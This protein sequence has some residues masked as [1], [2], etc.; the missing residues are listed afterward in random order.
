MG[1]LAAPTLSDMIAAQRTAVT[2]ARAAFG[3]LGP[4]VTVHEAILHKLTEEARRAGPFGRARALA[5]VARAPA[6]AGLL[7]KGLQP[8]HVEALRPQAE[9]NRAL[10]EVLE[11]LAGAPPT[12]R[13]WVRQRLEPLA[14]PTAWRVR[15]HRS[16]LPARLV[17]LTKKAYLRAL[18]PAARQV[19][20]GQRA[21]NLQVIAL[22][23]DPAL[24]R[25][26]SSPI[27]AEAP[28]AWLRPQH[29]FNQHVAGMLEAG[30][31]PGEPPALAGDRAAYVRQVQGMAKVLDFS[32]AEASTVPRHALAH[33]PRRLTWFLPFF[34]HPFGGVHTILRFADAWRRDHGVENR[35]VIYDNP[36]VTARELEAKVA[37]LYPEAPGT[38]EI[39]KSPEAVAGLAECDVAIATLWSSAYFALRHRKAR[40]RAYFIQDYEPLFY[41]AGTVS[42]LAQ[43]TYRLGF[44]GIFNTQGLYDSVTALHPMPG[45]WFEPAV[46]HAVF[47]AAGRRSDPG[48]IRVFFYG[49]PSVDRNGFELGVEALRLLKQQLGAKV[50]IFSAG[51]RWDP[52]AFDLQAVLENHGVLPYAQTANLYRGADVG[53]VFM[54]TRHPSYLPLELMACGVTVVT[55]QNPAN[56][57]LL[58]HRENCLLTQPTASSVAEQLVEAVTNGSLRE[59]I[60]Q[61]ATAR[62][63]STQWEAQTKKIW[64]ELAGYCRGGAPDPAR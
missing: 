56:D 63:S 28:F 64:A 51:E 49:R 53:L 60:A 17:E 36:H 62:M 55:N 57:W 46:D 21:W 33:P 50:Q 40:Q 26:L 41:P 6:D 34:N 27:A 47:H 37:L 61:E 29:E 2:A 22:V 10:V 42:A 16:G 35:F 31:D 9:F 20:A 14:D 25:A 23:E 39:L 13:A 54:F 3:P 30:Y 48:P 52:R 44:F 1:D 38:F 18:G 15:S 32:S 4:A 12:G 45:A 24:G 11:S 7:L 58:K 5:D 8:F 19:L 59:R 43:N